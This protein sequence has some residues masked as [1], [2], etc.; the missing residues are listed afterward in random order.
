MS[1]PIVNPFGTVSTQKI[2]SQ[3]TNNLQANT[4]IAPYGMMFF[5]TYDGVL[6]LGDDETPGGQII[7]TGGGGNGVPAAPNGSLQFNNNGV[8]G[9]NISLTFD[10]ANSILTLTGSQNVIGNISVVGNINV[11]GNVQA[12][13]IR[14]DDGIFLNSNVI[15]MSYTL[16]PG[17]NGITGGPITIENSA[18][19]TVPDGQRWTIV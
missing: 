18:V 9:G 11:A 13:S 3:W 19:V 14:D 2:K 7:G 1:L 4:W 8:F 15:T 5:D 17:Y 6:R 16:P 10:A 12:N